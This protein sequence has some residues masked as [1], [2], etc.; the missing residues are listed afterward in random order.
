MGSSRMFSL[1]LDSFQRDS[2]DPNRKSR[3]FLSTEGD[4]IDCYNLAQINALSKENMYLCQW[5]NPVLEVK[6]YGSLGQYPTWLPQCHSIYWTIETI[7][8]SNLIWN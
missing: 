7:P 3:S 1:L 4:K 8:I 6:V 2:V 5:Q